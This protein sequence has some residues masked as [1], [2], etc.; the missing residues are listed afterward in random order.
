VATIESELKKLEYLELVLKNNKLIPN[1]IANTNAIFD[2]LKILNIFF[3]D[4]ACIIIASIRESKIMIDLNIFDKIIVGNWKL[5]GTSESTSDYFKVLQSKSSIKFNICGIICPPSLL[6]P[7]FP[8]KSL[9]Y[10][11]GAQD[12]SVFDSGAYT[13]EI[14]ASMLKEKNC[15]F[16][17]LGHSERRQ[18]FNETNENIQLKV[19]R[20]IDQNINPIVCIGET[21]VEKDQ[22]LTRETLSKQ[23]EKSLPNNVSN[24]NIIIAYEPIWA[25]GTGLMPTLQEIN[26]IHNFI[27]NEIKK[28]KNYKVIYGGSV[29]S[30]NSSD[31]MS[32]TQVDG[33]LVGGS[34]LN[35]NEFIKILN[36]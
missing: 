34:S 33:V 11:L 5:N 14:S 29:K 3:Y 31:I 13:G 17:I 24:S 30:N 4:I 26:E 27:K 18:L 36:S 25:I 21:M 1:S 10:Y 6:L 23:I 9:P 35:P 32:L 2:L 20:L 19:K 15:Q 7:N 22:G 12:C 28:F 8:K 16:C